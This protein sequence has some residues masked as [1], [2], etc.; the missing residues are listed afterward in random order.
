MAFLRAGSVA[1]R[2]NEHCPHHLVVFMIENMAMPYITGATWIDEG[3]PVY[4]EPRSR[5]EGEQIAA[6]LR[7]AW[8]SA[9]LV[10]Q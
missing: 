5:I 7:H 10:E 8:Q 4:I 9:R 1:L 3:V 2:F 6:S